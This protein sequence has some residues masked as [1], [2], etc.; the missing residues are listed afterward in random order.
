MPRVFFLSLGLMFPCVFAHAQVWT[1]GAVTPTI[2]NPV[3]SYSATRATF[4]VG[5]A[6]AGTLNIGPGG[7]MTLTEG[8]AIL[9]GYGPSVGTFSMT[10]GT[11]NALGTYVHVAS[12]S[13]GG[14]FGMSGGVATIAAMDLGMTSRTYSATLSLTGGTLSMSNLNMGVAGHGVVTMSGGWLSLSTLVIASG[15]ASKPS[16]FDM[17][18][19]T[20]VS[21]SLRV[22]TGGT[23][24]MTVSN[25]T[26]NFGSVYV[27]IGNA[28]SSGTLTLQKARFD[29]TA[30]N[31][32]WVGQGTL[33]STAST[34]SSERLSMG[35]SKTSAGIFNIYGGS[36]T[37]TDS[38]GTTY[39]GWNGKATINMGDL[40]AVT[41]AGNVQAGVLTGGSGIINVQNSTLSVQGKLSLGQTTSGT[42]TLS[43]SGGGSHVSLATVSVGEA[44][45]SSGVLSYS[46][47]S[48]GNFNISELTVGEY[49]TGSYSSSTG[50]N[51]NVSKITMGKY[52]GAVGRVT[53]SSSDLT[54]SS[55]VVGEAGTGYFT[56][57][58]YSAATVGAL[59]LGNT[60]GSYGSLS[61]K[62]STF[63]VTNTAVV[64]NAGEGSFNLRASTASFGTLT[65]GQGSG[66]T[67]T[68]ST[69]GGRLYLNGNTYLGEAG[70]G[71]LDL[72]DG[73]V[74]AA[75]ISV[76]GAQGGAGLLKLNTPEFQSAY[77]RLN[78]TGTVE[79]EQAL[80][81]GGARPGVFEALAGTARLATLSVGTWGQFFASN[82]ANISA[83]TF[84]VGARG[85]LLFYVKG[86]QTND[87][88]VMSV[89]GEVDLSGEGI[90]TIDLSLFSGLIKEMDKLEILQASSLG[91]E[92]ANAVWKVVGYEQELVDH[93]L[94]A[95]WEDTTLVVGWAAIPEPSHAAAL[96]VLGALASVWARRRR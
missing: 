62:D 53:L 60:A 64:G 39:L 74:Q 36:F 52:A 79:G 43:I 14:F 93:V 5:S 6:S 42:G 83:M 46:G 32:G 81:V 80:V 9:L 77:L 88:R 12:G 75:T 22:G 67:G 86:D 58:Y 89:S 55:L 41:F 23:A 90:Y 21:E 34:V 48:Y 19:G 82:E 66:G 18:G 40:A 95:W 87:T 73:Y 2:A 71:T 54:T 50:R 51:Q 17:T 92:T 49:G 56:S 96:L 44:T 1:T 47:G 3:S 61:L 33:T 65:I 68:F 84:E 29:T 59:I 63:S 27:E 25:A 45:N 91:A 15:S 24:T 16:I 57:I 69:I 13:Y 38:R 20:L 72:N 4:Y 26:A 76:G 7:T 30:L 10:G 85:E 31:V 8:S 78:A 28:T 70:S 11:L 35:Y 37:T 94:K